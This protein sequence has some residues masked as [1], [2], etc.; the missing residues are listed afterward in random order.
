MNADVRDIS[1]ILQDL[2]QEL[3]QM[4]GTIDSQYLEICN[5]RRLV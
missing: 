2:M 3:Q 5:L 4:R 1:A